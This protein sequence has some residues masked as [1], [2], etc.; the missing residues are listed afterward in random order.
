MDAESGLVGWCGMCKT[1]TRDSRATTPELLMTEIHFRCERWMERLRQGA[2]FLAVMDEAD[3]WVAGDADRGKRM[4][5][6][7]ASALATHLRLRTGAV[8]SFAGFADL[9]D[10]EGLSVDSREFMADAE[11]MVRLV[12]MSLSNNAS[13]VDEVVEARLAVSLE[14]GKSLRNIFA[15]AIFYLADMDDR[16]RPVS[17]DMT[18]VSGGDGEPCPGCGEVHGPPPVSV[19]TGESLESLE[20]P[21]GLTALD[22]GFGEG[23]YLCRECRAPLRSQMYAVHGACGDCDRFTGRAVYVDE[24]N[25]LNVEATSL[26]YE[27]FD[28]IEGYAARVSQSDNDERRVLAH[29]M[30]EHLLRFDS[31]AD[32]VQY[33]FRMFAAVMLM[34][35]ADYH[36]SYVQSGRMPMLID[37]T[38]APIGFSAPAR[39]GQLYEALMHTMMAVMSGDLAVIGRY[40]QSQLNSGWA[41]GIMAMQ[42]HTIFAIGLVGDYRAEE[43]GEVKHDATS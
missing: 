36:R 39:H 1:Y 14:P 7:A 26:L 19:V 33:V 25:P 15:N 13:S 5:V 31:P 35:A 21:E 12:S 27:F 11:T 23:V 4:A 22:I 43:F 16:V 17:V 18:P 30:G 41:E 3:A 34:T 40:I 10:P 32:N 29:E 28:T 9:P 20:V 42:Q 6:G 37:G 8:E 2:D 24:N 38:V